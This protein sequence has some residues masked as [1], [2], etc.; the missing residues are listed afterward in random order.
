MAEHYDDNEHRAAYERA[1]D[2]VHYFQ[3]FA[4][5]VNE[6]LSDIDVNPDDIARDI[7]LHDVA[8]NH[9]SYRINIV[10]YD[11]PGPFDNVGVDG[12]QL[13]DQFG[14]CCPYQPGQNR[15]HRDI[16]GA[17]HHHRPAKPAP[18]ARGDDNDGGP[19]DDNYD[20]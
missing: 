17:Y 18:E 20:S 11:I 7:G 16:F 15:H 13:Y 8:R 6:Q 1:R 2:S 14:D 5:I 3:Q 12:V 9:P 19:D 10:I 4:G